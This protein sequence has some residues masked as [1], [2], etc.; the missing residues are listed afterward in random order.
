[1]LVGNTGN[2]EVTGLPLPSTGVIHACGATTHGLRFPLVH[3]ILAI[4][5]LPSP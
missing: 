1:M 4:L 3:S 2:L 5:L